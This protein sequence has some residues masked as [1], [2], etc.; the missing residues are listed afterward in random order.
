[1]TWILSVISIIGAILNILHYPIG[2]VL[3]AAADIVW[4]THDFC[5]GEYA[6]GMLFVI[7][8][9]LGVWGFWSWR[10]GQRNIFVDTMD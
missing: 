4:A 10:K 9:F 8:F 2:F 3:W 6:Q 5:I 1:M 7:Y